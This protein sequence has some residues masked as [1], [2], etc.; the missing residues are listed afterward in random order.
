MRA[1]LILL[2]V[3]ATTPAYGAKG[4]WLPFRRARPSIG[5]SLPQV[6]KTEMAGRVCGWAG[7]DMCNRLHTAW[8]SSHSPEWLPAPVPPPDE[9]AFVPTPQS[10]VDAMLAAVRPMPSDV[11]YD[12][13]CGDGRILITAV[14]EYGCQAV[15]IE[16]NPETA[17]LARAN[18]R[19]AGLEGSIVVQTGDAL[20]FSFNEATIVTMYLYVETME[21]LTPYIE[22]ATR[23]VSYSHPIPG[24]V[25]TKF[26]VG[27]HPVYVWTRE[28]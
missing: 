1:L 12:I 15:G 16:V 20:K 7:C 4:K 2:L 17:D 25:N 11:L 26:M 9:L 27:D 10:V 24:R 19:A 28:E 14:R 3:F 8:E 13:G 18:V 5:R 21:R 22:H 23:I 6:P